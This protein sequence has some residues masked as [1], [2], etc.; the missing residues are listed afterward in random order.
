MNKHDLLKN[1]ISYLPNYRYICNV[2]KDLGNSEYSYSELFV[3]YKQNTCAEFYRQLEYHF[4][5]SIKNVSIST[6]E[7]IIPHDKHITL[8]KFFSNNNIKPDT[9]DPPIYNLFI[10]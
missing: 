6:T 10:K 2:I 9:F 8:N 4:D 3:I 7:I 5:Q 1:Y